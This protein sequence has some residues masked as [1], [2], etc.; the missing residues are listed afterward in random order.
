MTTTRCDAMRCD[1]MS[2]R[3]SVVWTDLEPARAEDRFVDQVDPVR[4]TDDEH[5]VLLLEAVDLREEL[6]DH[7]VVH[8][9]GRAPR[10]R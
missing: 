1:S 10:N 9:R 3:A 2:L 4:D 8:A 5:I 7:V 6:V